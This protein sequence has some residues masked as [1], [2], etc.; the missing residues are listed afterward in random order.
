MAKENGNITVFGPETEFDGVL[1]FTDNLVITGKFHGTINS[2]GSLE[3]EKG[4]V[5]KVDA[6]KSA[7]VIISGSVEGNI[8]GSESV[9][10]CS[11]SSVKGD[12]TTSRL[13]I[14]DNV[15][16]EGSVSMLSDTTPADIFS[17]AS[18][19]YKS[20]LLLKNIEN[21]EMRSSK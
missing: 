11:G 7:S 4:A 5:C 1:E 12:I 14:A 19:E 15:E 20:A 17:V 2:T 6:I 18:K 16:F 21:A 8:E 13:R 10:L 3:I 9:E